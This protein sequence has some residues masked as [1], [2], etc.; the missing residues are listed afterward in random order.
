MRRV[1]LVLF[2]AACLSAQTA[3]TLEIGLDVNADTDASVAQGWP[4]LIRASLISAD[5][6]AVSLPADWTEA[7][8][9]TIT[10]PAGAPQNWP[11]QP[12]TP[13]TDIT[14]LAGM[15]TAEAVWLVAPA[16]TASIP[17]GVYSVR[18][19]LGGV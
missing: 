8:R 7:L 13:S 6:R 19:T 10:N 18:A 1:L 11:V 9:L 2:S 15:Q 16:A 5:G 4:L 3:S 14:N 17:V 12:V